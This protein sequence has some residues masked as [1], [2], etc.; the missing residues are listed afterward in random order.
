M[1]TFSSRNQSTAIVPAKRQD[2]WALLSD[3]DSLASLTPLVKGITAEGDEWCWNLAGISAL[4]VTVAP[5]FT[6]RMTFVEGEQI[7]FRHDPPGR[8]ERAGANGTYELSDAPAGATQLYID[9]T[10]CV[11]LPLPR[12][13]RRAVEGVMATTMAKTGD[14]FARNL[15]EKLGLDPADASKSVVVS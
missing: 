7:E 1:S 13:S 4:G 15:Y 9:I 10:I 11:E 12:L 2:I 5:T 8:N 6:E 14:R 3:A